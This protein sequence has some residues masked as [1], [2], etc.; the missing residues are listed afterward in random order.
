MNHHLRYALASLLASASLGAAGA[1]HADVSISGNVSPQNP[2]DPWDLGPNPLLVQGGTVDVTDRGSLISAGASI[3]AI[4]TVNTVRVLGYGSTWLNTGAIEISALGDPMAPAEGS[5]EIRNGAEVITDDLIL[6]AGHRDSHG[7]V[8]VEGYDATLTSR[9]NVHV[10]VDGEGDITLRQGATFFSNNVYMAVCMQCTGVATVAG[11]STRW[12]N[13]G[14]FIVGGAGGGTLDIYRAEVFTVNAVVKGR[15]FLNSFAFVRGWGGTWT[16]Q[17]LLRVGSADGYGML[18][19]QDLGTLVTEDTEIRGE[20]GPGAFKVLGAQ[21][22]WQNSGDVTVHGDHDHLPV[23]D[24]DTSGSV[25]IGGLL[26]TRRLSEDVIGGPG[27]RVRLARGELVAGSIEIETGN[28]AF[29]GGRLETGSFVG[30]LVNVHAGELSVGGAHVST[31]IAGSY[32]QGPSAALS[33]TVS[34]PAAAP[35]LQVDGDLHL[36]G[37][38]EVRAAGEPVLFEPGDTVTLLGWGGD[39]IGEFSAVSIALPLPPGLAWDTSALYT[40]GEITVV[41]G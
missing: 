21:A 8:L 31:V 13:T 15:D 28:L 32:E 1:A 39:L 29:L 3:W 24:I 6:A 7:H 34:G 23:L 9:G 2:S 16:N 25:R 38:L 27:P 41:P 37:A 20:A 12:V 5:L 17:G 14:D 35:L 19:V 4:S 18:I 36:D 10:G 33:I 26:R 40:T 30:D 22:S 11:S